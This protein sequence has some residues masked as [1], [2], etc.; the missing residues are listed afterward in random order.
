MLIMKL[1]EGK[2]ITDNDLENEL[3]E[4]CSR[5]QSGCNDKCPIYNKVLADK[6]K[7][8]F[9]CLYHKNGVRMLEALK[10]LSKSLTIKKNNEGLDSVEHTQRIPMKIWS[11]QLCD[12]YR[13]RGNCSLWENCLYEKCP[14]IIQANEIE[15]LKKV[16]QELQQKLNREQ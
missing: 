12:H 16:I 14:T 9:Y 10:A 13:G 15:A 2:E 3:Y 1:I 8:I 11:W 6:V 5:E 4:I 7:N